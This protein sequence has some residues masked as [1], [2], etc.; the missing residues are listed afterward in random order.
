MSRLFNDKWSMIFTADNFYL[1]PFFPSLNMW[2]LVIPFLS[3]LITE[4]V[5]L[6]Y[7]TTIMLSCGLVVVSYPFIR[8][9]RA[10]GFVSRSSCQANLE[11]TFEVPPKI[12]CKHGMEKHCLKPLLVLLN[13]CC[14][15]QR[16]LTDHT[17][18]PRIQMKRSRF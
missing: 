15:H 11:H 10:T 6:T 17:S 5:W 13:L 12:E 7:I 18:W 9:L 3:W 14:F 1:H 8:A 2:F 4:V 16:W